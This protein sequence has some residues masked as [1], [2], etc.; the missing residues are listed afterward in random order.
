[1]RCGARTIADGA[2]QPVLGYRAQA[3]V[4]ARELMAQMRCAD[5][6]CRGNAPPAHTEAQPDGAGRATVSPGRDLAT[7]PSELD[8]HKNNSRK[9]RPLSLSGGRLGL[10]IC[11]SACILAPLT[12]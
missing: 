7:P 8:N 1:M 6:R 11:A 3:E 5:D 2:D 4:L 12:P 9:W 10:Q